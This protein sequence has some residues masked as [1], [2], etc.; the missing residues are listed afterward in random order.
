MDN[1]LQA[2]EELKQYLYVDENDLLRE[3]CSNEAYLDDVIRQGEKIL[4]DYRDSDRN[5]ICGIL[6][7]LYRIK[8]NLEIALPFLERYK[9]YCFEYENEEVATLA[10]LRY[11]EALKYAHEH[12]EALAAFEEVLERCLLFNIEK[13]KNNA[14]QQLGKCYVEMGDMKKAENCFLKALVLRKKINDPKLLEASE[15][16]LNFMMHIKK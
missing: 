12:K 6:G 4:W 2:V 15:S 9:E 8:G 14:W 5:K 3:K 16:V 1:W 7:N 10:L 13:Y 11:A